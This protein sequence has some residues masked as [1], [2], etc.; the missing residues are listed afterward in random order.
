MDESFARVR[1]APDLDELVGDD[2]WAA[3]TDPE[4]SDGSTVIRPCPSR[5]PQAR[6][7]G[8]AGPQAVAHFCF[9]E[10]E[11]GPQLG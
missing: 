11:L 3:E 10:Q 9:C 5:G 4:D 7:R 6:S 2:A 8:R 1:E